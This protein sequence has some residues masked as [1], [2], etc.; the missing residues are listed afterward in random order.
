[1]KL[2]TLPRMIMGWD[3]P[4]ELYIGEDTED[5]TVL[6][7]GMDL[8]RIREA[9]LQAL[10]DF[11]LPAS[12]QT[13]AASETFARLARKWRAETGFLSSPTKMAMHPAY[14]EIIGLGQ[15]A[16]PLLLGKLASDPSYWF[17]ALRAITKV[18]P[19]PAADRGHMQK[20]RDAWLKW[21]KDQGYDLP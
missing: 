6:G 9:A 13:E 20:M 2:A 5:P 16:V 19:V 14:Q 17:W 10:E 4:T 15:S 11:V 8:L 1:M 3:L 12:R 7:A 21:G 18:D